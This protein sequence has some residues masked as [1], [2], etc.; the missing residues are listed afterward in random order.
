MMPLKASRRGCRSASLISRGNN[1][2]YGR[3]EDQRSQGAGSGAREHGPRRVHP[4]AR[5]LRRAPR[6][7]RGRVLGPHLAD[8]AALAVGASTIGPHGVVGR[9]ARAGKAEPSPLRGA[10]AVLVLFTPGIVIYI[11]LQLRLHELGFR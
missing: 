8:D 4:P 2:R 6:S 9:W 5:G 1:A 7:R 3:C 10:L 11:W